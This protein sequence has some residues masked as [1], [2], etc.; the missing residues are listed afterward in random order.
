MDSFFVQRKPYGTPAEQPTDEM[1]YEWIDYAFIVGHN[2]VLRKCKKKMRRL[3]NPDRILKDLA[4]SS[5]NWTR[6][7]Q[8]D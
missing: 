7:E 5:N 2:P 1:A 3:D 8:V 6:S 4:K